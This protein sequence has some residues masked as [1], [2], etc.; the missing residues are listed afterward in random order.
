MNKQIFAF[1]ICVLFIGFFGGNAFADHH[2]DDDDCYDYDENGDCRDP[3]DYL[4]DP[5]YFQFEGLFESDSDFFTGVYYLVLDTFGV[6]NYNSKGEKYEYTSASSREIRCQLNGVSGGN[7]LYYVILPIL[8]A[9]LMFW[10]ILDKVNLFDAKIQKYMAIALALLMAPLGAYRVLFI[11]LMSIMASG[12]IFLLYIFLFVLMLGWGYKNMY[13]AGQG[14]ITAGNIHMDGMKRS[15]ETAKN[16]DQEIEN[17]R[18]NIAD[19]SSK[20]S[21][22]I[23]GK[24]PDELNEIKIGKEYL[25][26]NIK[27]KNLNDRL[28]LL[29]A[30]RDKHLNDAHESLKGIVGN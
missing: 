28:S 2:D 4:Y 22:L 26:Y 12:T 3:S 11:G 16:I 29:I 27:L 14:H 9:F 25:A 18:N 24:K 6:C 20:Q 30:H 1:L 17:V 5:F 19:T 15:H 7:L 8:L 21:N 10:G 13:A 23:L